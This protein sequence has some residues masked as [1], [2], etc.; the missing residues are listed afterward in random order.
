MRQVAFFFKEAME[1]ALLAR[2][3][4]F[5]GIAGGG[6]AREEQRHIHSRGTWQDIVGNLLLSGATDEAIA[7]IADTRVSTVRT[8]NDGTTG[9][10][11]L[12]N[13]LSEAILIALAIGDHL[14]TRNIKGREQAPG[15]SR[16]FTRD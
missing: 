14:R 8:E 10:R 12:K 15:P 1:G 2:G 7:R 5:K 6:E 11:R 4:A 16:V 13:T 9:T 3:K